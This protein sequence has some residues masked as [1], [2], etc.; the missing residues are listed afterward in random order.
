MSI[1]LPYTYLIGWSTHNKWYYGVRYAK[2]KDVL[3]E[4]GCHPDDLWVTYH[5]SSNHVREFTKKHGDPDIIQVRKTFDKEESAKQWEN[6]VLRRMKVVDSEKWLNKRLG[7]SWKGFTTEGMIPHNKIYETYTITCEF[8]KK[9][10]DFKYTRDKRGLRKTCGSK[11]CVGKWSTKY[12]PRKGFV[13]SNKIE[14]T[15]EWQCE[16][17][18]KKEIRRDT[19]KQRKKRFC[20]KSCAATYSNLFG[21]R[22]K[23]T[24]NLK[25][26]Q[27]SI[28]QAPP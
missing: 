3:Y 15:F 2:K 9:T 8:C 5:T 1:Y 20:N 21:G 22:S 24:Y 25:N 19:H 28:E 13:P 18:G 11:S 10:C 26:R 12:K 7:T 6:K 4:T 23:S 17:C 27:N 14:N 16:T